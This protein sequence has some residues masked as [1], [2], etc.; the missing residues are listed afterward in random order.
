[1]PGRIGILGGGAFGTALADIPAQKGHAVS[2]WMREPGL[3][4]EFNATRVNS[5]YLPGLRLSENITATADPAE[6]V[7]D[8]SLVLVAI[9]S[10]WFRETVKLFASSLTAEQMIVSTTK[11]LEPGS[12]KRMSEILAQE[13]PCRR[14]GALSG[15][16]LAKEIAAH[17]IS[18]TVIASPHPE[19]IA[20]AQEA[21]SCGYF[22]V[23]GNPDVQGV[24]LGGLL[25]N[26]YAI[27]TGIADALDLG[28]NAKG[29]LLTRA[30]T[31]MGRFAQRSGADP[32]TFLGLA[33]IGDLITTCTSP[34]SRNFRVGRLIGQGRT[35]D[36]AVKELGETAEG[37]HTVKIVH[38]QLPQLGIRMR[39]L[40]GLHAVLFEGRGVKEILGGLM[41]EPQMEDVEFATK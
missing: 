16:N 20:A 40:E 23:Y 31:E 10:P 1:M 27:A 15:P 12:F 25:K 19:L 33:G 21:F 3:A 13:T 14:I 28:D 6:A 38:D 8:A 24:E 4:A 9:P 18:G 37:V 30:V 34:L 41:N 29:M 32:L 17:R 11:G 22:R 39:I 5:R 35:L 26:V 2:L 7:R 36:E